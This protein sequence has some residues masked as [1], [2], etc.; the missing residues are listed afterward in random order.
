MS[1]TKVRPELKRDKRKANPVKTGVG[2]VT[3][4]FVGIVLLFLGG[5]ES[6]SPRQP[7]AA[8][9]VSKW[10]SAGTSYKDT[11]TYEGI[12]DFYAI[13]NHTYDILNSD[14]VSKQGKGVWSLME[15]TGTLK[16]ENDT[17]SVYIGTFQDQTF[18]TITMIT[19]NKQWGLVLTKKD[20]GDV[21]PAAK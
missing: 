13:G 18:T 19:T 15:G 11:R 6:R 17:G 21:I 7:T 20:V 9:L 3:A 16:V 5:C 12:F 10:K 8:D 4:A 14:G 1:A 2:V